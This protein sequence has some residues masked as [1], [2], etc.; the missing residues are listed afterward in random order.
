MNIVS[1]H[2]TKRYLHLNKY[3]YKYLV[4]G[5]CE[6]FGNPHSYILDYNEAKNSDTV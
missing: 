6:K 4:F 1:V 2:Q 5:G 3:C